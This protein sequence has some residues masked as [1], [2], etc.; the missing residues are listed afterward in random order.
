M[1]PSR[2]NS[3]VATAAVSSV[4]VMA[5]DALAG[6]VRNRVGSSGISGTL[7]IDDAKLTAAIE[8]NFSEVASYLTD[9]DGLMGR[10]SKSVDGYIKTGGVIQQ[11]EA[12]LQSTHTSIDEQRAALNLRIEKMQTRLVAKFTALDT[13]VT[14]LTRTSEALGTQLASLPGFVKKD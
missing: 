6:P 10:L 14:S 3:G 13:L 8:N 1:S 12:G 5:Q 2:P 9:E 7:V 4:A 11:R